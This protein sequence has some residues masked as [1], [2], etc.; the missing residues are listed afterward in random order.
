MAFVVFFSFLRMLTNLYRSVSWLLLQSW[1]RMYSAKFYPGTESELQQWILSGTVCCQW[2]KIWPFQG[3]FQNSQE[4]QWS[5]RMWLKGRNVV[6]LI[7]SYSWTAV[8][9]KFHTPWNFSHKVTSS[10]KVLGDGV[11]GVWQESTV[12]FLSYLWGFLSSTLPH[13]LYSTISTS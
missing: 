6:R 1:R 10:G 3:N 4:K 9:S 11:I 8:A 12:L 2:K 13:P 5:C 7:R